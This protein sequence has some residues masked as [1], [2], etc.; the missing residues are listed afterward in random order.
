MEKS[1][2]LPKLGFVY[3]DHVMRFFDKSNF[4]GWPDKIAQVTYHWGNDKKRFI[5]EVKRKEIDVL[6]GNIPAT[7]YETFR[8]I[9]RA[10]PNV[11]FI[12]SLDTQFSNKSKEN[13]TNFCKKYD[14]PI[15]KTEVFYEAKEATKYLS[16]CK[17]P[18]L[19]RN[20][21]VLQIMVVTSSIKL[22]TQKKLSAYWRKRNITRYMFRNLCQ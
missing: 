2:Q 15:P 21:M 16:Q 12:P 22:I 4:K 17:Y 9:S 6:I 7:A 20:L 5:E 19:L 8:E 3:L 14:L 1:A 18:K 11:Q 13:V 10:L